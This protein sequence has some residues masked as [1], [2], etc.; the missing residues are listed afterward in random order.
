MR[1]RYQPL[2][3]RS[4]LRAPVVFFLRA[5]VQLYGITLSSLIGAHCRHIPTCSE[6]AD[7]ALLKHGAARGLWL[8]LRRVMSCHPFSRAQRHDPVP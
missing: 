2:P 4:M 7:E 6:Y 3:W 8:A 5:L 1:R